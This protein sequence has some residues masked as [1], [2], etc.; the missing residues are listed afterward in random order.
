VGVSSRGRGTK[1]LAAALDAFRA[2]NPELLKSEKAVL[3]RLETD[4][5]AAAAFGTLGANGATA[6]LLILRCL[7]A[8]E[9]LDVFAGEVARSKRLL[10]NTRKQ[11]ELERL[12]KGLVAFEKFIKRLR[13]EP[14][15]R[16][17]AQH[18]LAPGSFDLMWRFQVLASDIIAGEKRI[19]EET[20]KR[21][22]ATRNTGPGA[23]E[24]AAIGWIANAVHQCSGEP[25]RK[26]VVKLAEVV[27]QCKATVFRVREAERTRL[28]REWRMPLRTAATDKYASAG[29]L[30][31]RQYVASARTTREAR[32]SRL[33]EKAPLD[34]AISTDES[35]S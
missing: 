35:R 19:A 15:G 24:L 20:P 25:N 27:L 30:L 17:W 3:Q 18:K 21:F 8:A 34:P 14:V 5:R 1:S 10:G 29:A 32:Q 4:R 16:V 2:S 31:S 12:E 6:E 33:V 28:Q 22:G 7:E 13:S 9:I 11:G 26:S 23:A